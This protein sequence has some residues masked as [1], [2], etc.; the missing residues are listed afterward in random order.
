MI[1]EPNKTIP[2]R[3]ATRLLLLFLKEKLAEEVRGDLDE[4]FYSMV[5]KKSLFRARID[6]WFQVMNYLRPF[7]IRNANNFYLNSAGMYQNYIKIAYRNLLRQKLY[8]G[9]NIGGLAAGLACFIIIVLYVQ[10][11]FSFDRFYNNANRIYRVYQ[12]QGGNIYLGS[13]VFGLTPSRLAS[14]IEAEY[15]EV[16]VATA[17][18]EKWALLSTEKSNFWEKGIAGDSH[19]FGVFTIPFI[20]G[21]PKLALK[22]AKSIVLTKSLADKIFPNGDPMG[23]SLKYQNG[24]IYFVTGIVNDPPANSSLQYTYIVNILSDYWYAENLKRTKWNNNNVHTFFVLAENANPRELEMKF[25]ALLKKYK[26]PVDYANYPFDDKYLIQTMPSMYMT[27]GVNFDIGLKGNERYVWL[28]SAVAVIVLLLA[29]VNY[30]NLAIARSIKRAREVGLRKVVGAVRAQ[31]IGQFL[32]ESI[33]ITFISLGLAISL[34]YILL[35]VF[36]DVMERPIELNFLSNSWLLPGLFML[37]LTVGILAGSYPALV[38]SSLRPADVLKGRTGP[39]ASGHTLQRSLVVFQYF[40]SIVLIIGSIVIYQQLQFMKQKELGYDKE[41]VITIDMQDHHLVTKIDNLRNEWLQYPAI[42]DVTM[43]TQLPINVT[44]SHMINDEINDSESDDIAIYEIRTDD[45]FINTFGIQLIAGRNFSI[46]NK[47]DSAQSYLINEKAAKALGWTPEEAVG[48]QIVDDGPKTIV[49]VVKDFHIHSLHLPIEPLMI[50]S[51]TGY[52]N[53]ICVKVEKGK[54]Q[55][56]IAILETTIKKHSPWPFEYQFLDERF[57]QLY[58]SEMKLGE[59]FGVFTVVTILIASLGLFGLAAFTTGQRTKEI[60]IRKVLGA[61][62]QQVVILLSKDFI[63][64]VAIAFVIAVPVG[65]Y[66]MNSWLSDFAYR[67]NI[68][69]WTFAIAGLLALVIAKAT[70]SYQSIRASVM[71]PVESLMEQ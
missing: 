15:P 35:P 34:T 25:P 26:D 71:N 2:P 52:G 42:K 1:T 43:S 55:E 68:E 39:K 13:D 32:G 62:A 65:W 53:F 47:S 37:V 69:W 11:E 20:Q 27:S 22:D 30:M 44:S 14:V 6:Y 57:D 58:Q 3:P 33:M 70:I 63:R 7:A 8:A 60:G 12:R 48:K 9:I 45:D 23:Q 64:L 24:D 17:V 67:I 5:K 16:E 21:N 19:F 18:D 54:E 36:G 61:S 46:K 41:G 4:R 50:R 29:C 40:A 56:A 10:H 59:I 38:M 28:F 31:L 66:S 49:G 51:Y